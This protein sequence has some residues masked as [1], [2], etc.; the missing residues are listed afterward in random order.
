MLRGA[1]VVALAVLD[2]VL[3]PG[4][5]LLAAVD[6]LFFAAAPA[7]V[8]GLVLLLAG[9]LLPGRKLL[10]PFGLTPA[11]VP[12]RGLFAAAAAVVAVRVP[13]AVTVPV[14]V[15]GVLAAVDEAEER[16]DAGPLVAVALLARGLFE[17]PAAAE[18][19]ADSRA[20]PLLPAGLPVVALLALLV[21]RAAGLLVADLVALPGLLLGF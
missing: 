5:L 17:A 11:L 19:S 3:L 16:R 10:A 12:V 4:L 8:R 1:P 18:V 6:A 14:L 15:R 13:L 20:I 2:A 9:E 21:G 7:P